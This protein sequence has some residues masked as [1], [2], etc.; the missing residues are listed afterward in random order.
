MNFA[1]FK[2]YQEYVAKV[3]RKTKEQLF[4]KRKSIENFEVPDFSSS[5]EENLS[6]VKS[7][8]LPTN[9]ITRIAKKPIQLAKTSNNN[10][11][12]YQSKKLE[13]VAACAVCFIEADEYENVNKLI[14]CQGPCDGYIHSDCYGFNEL[15][16]TLYHNF[17]CDACV[18]KLNSSRSEENISTCYL[19]FS[20]DGLMKK[21]KCGKLCHT[22]CVL[23]CAE[24]TVENGVANNLQDIDP[25]RH[26]LVCLLCKKKGGGCV[27]CSFGKCLASFHPYCAYKNRVLLLIREEESIQQ[28]SN[29]TSELQKSS[30]SSS[31]ATAAAIP[32][33]QFLDSSFLS[34][35]QSIDNDSDSDDATVATIATCFNYELYCY[36]HQQFLNRTNTNPII[37][38]HPKETVSLINNNTRTIIPSSSSSSSSSS[39]SL[40]DTRQNMFLSSSPN[41]LTQAVEEQQRTNNNYNSNHRLQSVSM[42]NRYNVTNRVQ[43]RKRFVCV[44][45]ILCLVYYL[46]S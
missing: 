11:E 6:N 42:S 9:A 26:D 10:T 1:S 20:S 43:K 41:T 2:A 13:S 39:A 17:R 29:N 12:L 38:A 32:R 40:F 45:H 28:Q 25:D 16:S 23:F 35:T 37:S 22:I 30:S 44:R 27:Q 21:S 4:S 15:D 3:P 31:S 19:C 36:D 46:S 34:Q 8:A 24:L 18:S 5:D 33:S 7:R 14:H